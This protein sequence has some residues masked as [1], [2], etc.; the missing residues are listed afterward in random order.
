MHTRFFECL[1]RRGLSVRQA[2]LHATF[3]KNPTPAAGLHQQELDPTF[4]DAVADGSNL[5]ALIK[6]RPFLQRL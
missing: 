1:Q 6:N 2:M 3:R 5:F 4:S